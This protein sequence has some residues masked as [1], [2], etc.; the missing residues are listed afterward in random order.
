MKTIVTSFNSINQ[1]RPSNYKKISTKTMVPATLLVLHSYD[2]SF[3]SFAKFSGKLAS[4][5]P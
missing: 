4:L 3:S 1:C 5:T 2:H